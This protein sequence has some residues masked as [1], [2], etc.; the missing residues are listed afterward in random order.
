MFCLVG[1]LGKYFSHSVKILAYIL[2][3]LSGAFI[4]ILLLMGQFYIYAC[5]FHG[6]GNAETGYLIDTTLYTITYVFNYN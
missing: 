4:V 5:L 2:H 1:F 6:Y 3:I